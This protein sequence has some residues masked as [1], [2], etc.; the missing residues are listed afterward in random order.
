MKK[1]FMK[2]QIS[3]EAMNELKGGGLQRCHCGGTTKQ[4][5]VTSGETYAQ[6]EKQ[7]GSICGDAGWACTPI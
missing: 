2:F 1:D 3:K 7:V 5:F 6:L 4:E